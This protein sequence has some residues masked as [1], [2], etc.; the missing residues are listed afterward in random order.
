MYEEYEKEK[1]IQD[2]TDKEKENELIMS[3]IRV[4]EDL[5]MANINF[6][7]ADSEL[8]DYYTYQI[9]ANRSKLDYLIKKA[10]SNGIVLDMID[11]IMY[12]FCNQN[13][14]VG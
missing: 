1:I 12:R 14:E 7:Y 10:K 8:I 3:I 5:K 11:E 9:K 4:R 6:E 13:N 2:K